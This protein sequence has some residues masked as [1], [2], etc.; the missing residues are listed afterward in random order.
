MALAVVLAAG[1]LAGLAGM[2]PR[3][4]LTGTAGRRAADA[5]RVFAALTAL[6]L[7][8]GGADGDVIVAGALTAAA[9]GRRFPAAGL[10]VILVAAVPALRA[11]SSAV[12]DVAG[13]QDVLGPAVL[14]PSLGVA[15]AASLAVLSSLVTASVLIPP[16]PRGGPVA[17][18]RFPGAVA[19]A[20]VPAAVVLLGVMAA[21]GPPMAAGASM[22][23]LAPRLS[24]AAGGLAAAAVAR[25]LTGRISL[26][27]RALSG[28]AAAALAVT[29]AVATP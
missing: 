8:L 29:L 9:L 21:T 11:G 4:V 18:V 28:A 7:S 17:V 13:V 19:D 15:L 26:D 25:R 27:V 3:A 22:A 2:K 5:L 24:G 20:L 23:W 16:R 1:A 14:S 6:S 12:E 10:S